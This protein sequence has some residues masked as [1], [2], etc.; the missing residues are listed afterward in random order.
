MKEQKL[1]LAVSCITLGIV[2]I[3]IGQETVPVKASPKPVTSFLEVVTSH[4]LMG[5]LNWTGIFLFSLAAIPLG[6]VSVV[7]STTRSIRQYPLS[8]KLLIMATIGVFILGLFG[9]AQGVICLYTEAAN[10]TPDVESLALSMSFALFSM[11]AALVAC[12]ID[13]LFLLIS[14]I[15]LHS[16]FRNMPKVHP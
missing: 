7:Q 1:V 13:L 10:D 16:K 5:L 4:G 12:L 6:I 9:V 8:T 3:A 11:A 15:I 2:S 14:V